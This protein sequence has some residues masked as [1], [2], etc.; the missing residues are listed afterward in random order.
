MSRSTIHGY[1]VAI[2]LSLF[3]LYLDSSLNATWSIQQL[4]WRKIPLYF[5]ALAGVV[6]L[7]NPSWVDRAINVGVTLHTFVFFE[8]WTRH[9]AFSRL[10]IINL[11]AILCKTVHRLNL[12]TE[13]KRSVRSVRSS[14]KRSD[15]SS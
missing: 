15:K 7:S 1:C 10:V 3:C 14:R 6:F 9:D 13:R 2:C 11:I 5:L 8:H 4:P 12:E